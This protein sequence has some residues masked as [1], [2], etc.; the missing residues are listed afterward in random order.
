MYQ[1]LAGAQGCVV[2]DVAVLIRPDVAVQQPELAVFYQ[3]V[4]VFE[5]RAASPDRF[6][7]STG[8]CNPSLKFFQQEV[9]MRSDPIYRGIT[10]PRCGGIAAGIFLRIR[11]GWLRRLAWHGFLLAYLM[12]S[13]ASRFCQ[14]APVR[15]RERE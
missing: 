9:V 15:W 10:L 2:E 12:S 8:K 7:L 11:P 1:Q 13:G 6:N 5:V 4:S 14:V 3:P